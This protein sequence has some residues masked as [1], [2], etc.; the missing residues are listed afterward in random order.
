[1]MPEHEKRFSLAQ[2]LEKEKHS[3][4]KTL[5][6]CSAPS[7]VILDDLILSGEALPC[8]PGEKR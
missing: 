8:Y 6:P 4:M 2:R 1:M 7:P 5:R 3:R